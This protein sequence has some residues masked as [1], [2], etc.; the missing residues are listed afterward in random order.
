MT[1]TEHQRKSMRTN[2][3]QKRFV[4]INEYQRKSLKI[5]EHQWKSK[6]IIEHQWKSDGRHGGET[7][8]VNLCL[9]N[10]TIMQMMRMVCGQV[11]IAKRSST[12][13]DGLNM[14]ALMQTQSRSSDYHRT[15]QLASLFHCRVLRRAARWTCRSP[16]K[17]SCSARRSPSSHKSH[18]FVKSWSPTAPCLH[19]HRIVEYRV[20]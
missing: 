18:I 1:I 7:C 14:F 5:H 17:P 10:L 2:E 13:V 12:M 8:D 9:G 11:I 3:N 6:K 20:E 16:G 15:D 4:K 19:G